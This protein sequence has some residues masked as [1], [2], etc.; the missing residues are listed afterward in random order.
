MLA[1]VETIGGGEGEAT[2][3]IVVFGVAASRFGIPVERVREMTS[4]GH[5]DE[6]AGAPPWVAGVIRIREEVLPVVDL[7]LRLG[8]PS[9]DEERDRIIQALSR[10]QRIHSEWLAGLDREGGSG[11]FDVESGA[12]ELEGDSAWSHRIYDEVPRLRQ[13]AE[14]AARTHEALHEAVREAVSPAIA[15]E[16]REIALREIRQGS[17]AAFQQRLDELKRQLVEGTRPMVITL[18]DGDASTCIQVDRVHSVVAFGDD[19]VESAPLGTLVTDEGAD[20]V[21][22]VVKTPND[23]RVVQIL[24]IDRL[25]GAPPAVD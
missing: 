12:C 24:D 14:R 9:L 15:R 7:R 19:Q 8:M 13:L 5:V 16:R 11:R 10:S 25:L 4:L 2:G 6:I 23:P 1:G 22:R 20:L 3:Q 21:H 18:T 17:L